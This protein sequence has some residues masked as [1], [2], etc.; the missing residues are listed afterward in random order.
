MK[1]ANQAA[2]PLTRA[3]DR[4][5]LSTLAEPGPLGEGKRGHLS[6]ERAAHQQEFSSQVVGSLDDYASPQLFQTQILGL[7]GI[8]GG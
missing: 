6:R 5:A 3:K 4:A 1:T 7:Q 2:D 8:F